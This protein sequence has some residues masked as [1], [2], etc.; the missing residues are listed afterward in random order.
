MTE[1]GLHNGNWAVRITERRNKFGFWTSAKA[2]V[3]DWLRVYSWSQATRRIWQKVKWRALWTH[4][5]VPRMYC[6]PSIV[7]GVVY[8]STGRSQQNIN[9]KIIDRGKVVKRTWRQTPQDLVS[10]NCIGGNAVI[11][12][13]YMLLLLSKELTWGCVLI[14][15]F[16]VYSVG[17]TCFFFQH[18]WHLQNCWHRNCK[19]VTSSDKASR[20]MIAS[21]VETLC[22]LTH[23]PAC[24]VVGVLSPSLLELQLLPAITNN[25]V[26]VDKLHFK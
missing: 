19:Q 14:K 13:M 21:L 20:A 22:C 8:L 12:K 1:V 5:V 2:E 4:N 18:V 25:T 15:T 11:I 7:E 6:V 9:D 24:N 17:F 16:R 3:S 26:Y 10:C 23:I